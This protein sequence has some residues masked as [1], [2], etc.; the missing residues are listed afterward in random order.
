MSWI[1]NFFTS[2]YVKS[3]VR[4]LIMGFIVYLN[5]DV[6]L[7]YLDSLIE[8]LTQ[9]SEILTEIITTILMGLLGSWTVLKNKQNERVEQLTRVRFPD[10][11]V[12]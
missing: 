4:Y 2:R 3:V 6:D 12:K 7:P 5:K 10:V 9:N 1:K 11:R 8:F